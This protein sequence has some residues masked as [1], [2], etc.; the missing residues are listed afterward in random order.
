[1]PLDAYCDE[2]SSARLA[3]PAVAGATTYNLYQNGL[4]V[5]SANQLFANITGLAVDTDYVFSL[6]ATVAGVERPAYQ[7]RALRFTSGQPTVVSMARV[8]PFPSVGWN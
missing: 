5:L 8:I 7:P 2:V 3:W 4:S 6:T 1:M